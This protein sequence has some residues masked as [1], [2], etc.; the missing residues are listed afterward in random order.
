VTLL[1]RSCAALACV[2][3]LATTTGCA[4]RSHGIA[5]AAVGLGLTVASGL[6][7]NSCSG[8]DEGCGAVI[9]SLVPSIAI[10]AFGTVG[11]LTA[12]SQRSLTIPVAPEHVE[13]PDAVALTAR[14][15]VAAQ[16]G[17][18]TEVVKLAERVELADPEYYAT[19]FRADPRLT[20][21]L[22]SGPR[23][24]DAAP[25]FDAGPMPDAAPAPDAIAPP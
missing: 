23:A 8:D 16:G 19:T 25:T 17:D 11:A 24:V 13:D 7:I 1:G 2:T 22:D 20:R 4:K 14:A 5:V 12:N 18:C 3:L 6:A 21:C 15:R 10:L 9:Y